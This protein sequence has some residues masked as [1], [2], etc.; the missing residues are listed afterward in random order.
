MQVVWVL[1]AA[2]GRE[3]LNSVETIVEVV[4]EEGPFSKL[5]LIL[6]EN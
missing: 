1:Q 2:S 4:R 5:R 6:V 3:N